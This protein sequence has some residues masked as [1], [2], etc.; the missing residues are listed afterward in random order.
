MKNILKESPQTKLSGRLKFT[1]GQFVNKKD[2]TRK[3]VLNIGCGYGWFELWSLKQKVGEIVGIEIDD[4]SLS[5]ARTISDPRVHF[6]IGSAIKLPF[7]DNSFDTVVSWEVLEH[8]PKNTEPE[9]FSEVNRV[10]KNN[11]TFYLSTPHRSLVTCTMDPAWWLID[12][13]HYSLKD[14]RHLAK[15]SQF[16]VNKIILRGKWY[17]IFFML[18]LYFSKWVLRR[19]PLFD[20]AFINLVDKDYK[21]TAG[22]TT[23]FARLINQ[24]K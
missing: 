8:I 15:Q 20:K 7:K 4:E 9:M 13:R 24:K 23:I 22:F 5:A 6:R 2:I 21:E 3:K 1:T 14:I 12:H 17:E 18:N 16:T 11:G 19:A 10:L